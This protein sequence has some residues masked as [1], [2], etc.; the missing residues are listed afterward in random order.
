MIQWCVPLLKQLFNSSTNDRRDDGTMSDTETTV[1]ITWTF[2][3]GGRAAAGFRG[4][5][6]DCVV[7]AIAIATG[8]SYRQVYNDLHARQRDYLSRTRSRTRK[9]TKTGKARSGS[10]REGIY[11]EVYKPYL[12]ELGWSWVPVMG[13]GTGATMHLSYVEL[14]DEPVLI[15]RLS[16]HLATVVH[17]TVRD[18][19]DPSR[20]GKRTIY[21]YFIPHPWKNI[22]RPA[23]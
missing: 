10:P 8:L 23:A 14:P 1:A 16:K 21:G 12:A 5:T 15:V 17:G 13:I 22:A 9:Y 4:D 20:E 11:A 3:D 7:R 6:G 2:D 19:F 18:T